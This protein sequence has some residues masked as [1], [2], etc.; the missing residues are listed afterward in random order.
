M[1][2]KLSFILRKPCKYSVFEHRVLRSIL[3]HERE[4]IGRHKRLCNVE[5]QSE[6]LH[7]HYS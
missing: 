1:D 7:N 4:K 6:E 3:G 5:L 2:V